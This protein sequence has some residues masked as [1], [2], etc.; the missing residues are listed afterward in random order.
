MTDR[1]S[2]PGYPVY[3][4]LEPYQRY[5]HAERLFAA[6]QFTAA[7]AELEQLLAQIDDHESTAARQLLA[8]SYF[9]SAQLGRAESMARTLLA[10]DPDDGYAA[11]LLARSLERQ[12]RHAEA[13]AVRRRAEALG[14]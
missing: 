12:S 1:R 7:C 3:P 9:H 5:R 2:L 10:K 6:E 4:G 13:G 11:L 14:A 8:R